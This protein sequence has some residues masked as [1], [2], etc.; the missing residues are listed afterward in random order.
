MRKFVNILFGVFVVLCICG[1]IFSQK[2]EYATDENGWNLIMVNDEYHVPQNYAVELTQLDNGERVD[3]RIYPALQEMF[4][5][6]EEEGI[7]MVVAEGYRTQEDQQ[8]LMD[9]KVE[10]Y[11]EKVLVKFVAQW[12]A[13]K[14]VAVP[15]TSEHQLGIAVDINADGIHSAGSE[16]YAWLAEHAHEY[17]FIQRYPE[18]KTEITGINYE[19]WHYRYVGEDVAGEIYEE[20]ICLEEYIDKINDL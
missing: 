10:E 18:D 19:P 16:V 3:K 6:A 11:Q 17:G 8:E 2:T 1:F 14:W 15:G 4:D 9:E 20:D 13:E 7:Y 12:F 5:A